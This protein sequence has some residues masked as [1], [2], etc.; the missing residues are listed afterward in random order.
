[1]KN[2]TEN[3][4]VPEKT[5]SNGD[6][7]SSAPGI[8]FHVPG[9]IGARF[10]S[11]R[12][13]LDL[14]RSDTTELSYTGDLHVPSGPVAE[15]LS[16][17]ASVFGSEYSIFLCT[18]S[19]NGIRVM[20]SAVADTS[21]VILLPRSVH[22]SVVWTLAI[23]GCSYLFWPV[24]IPGLTDPS[25]VAIPDANRLN[26]LLSDHPEVTDVFVTSPDYYGQCADLSQIA[27]IAHDHGCR[28]LVDEAH[29]AHFAFGGESYP[30]TA[31]SSGADI[32]VQSLH[33]TLPA[34]TPS[35]VIH[36]SSGADRNV[37]VSREKILERIGI[38]ETSSP[39]F[40][41]ASSANIAI[42]RLKKGGVEPFERAASLVRRLSD[43]LTGPFGLSAKG[44]ELPRRKDPLRMVLH[45]SETGYRAPDVQ[46]ALE[47]HRIYAEFADLER[48]VF[49]FS[50]LHEEKEYEA[51][52]QAI[53]S[54]FSDP[55]KYG[56]SL[57]DHGKRADRS[58]MVYTRCP[59]RVISLREA[60]FSPQP[61]I[62]VDLS[63]MAGKISARA[64][65]L[66]PPGISLVWPGERVSDEIADYL[67]H[68]SESGLAPIG[69]SDGQFVSIRK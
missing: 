35:A 6:N 27:S 14:I 57:I 66:Y 67:N 20:L 38:F 34:L 15:S 65:G 3:A 30:K 58:G 33:K 22:F 1:V 44:T 59:E 19:T 26:Q 45:T 52:Y 36:V 29:G 5:P 64:I 69:L 37:R 18:G 46:K 11:E 55:Y 42:Q 16:N 2:I 63:E 47:I 12:D 32:C 23:I 43:R 10:F 8:G 50:V 21:S 7:S 68:A 39:S 17:S 13:C 49:L 24:D 56:L 9:H 28:L 51:L 31:M 54:I 53:I 25:P 61:L 40:M 62:N 60:V 48:L 4:A 41:I